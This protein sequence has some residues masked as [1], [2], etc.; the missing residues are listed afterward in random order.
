MELKLDEIEE[1]HLDWI[2]L[3]QDFYGPFHAVVDGALGKIEHAGGAASPYKCLK[4]G[5]PMVYRISKNGF[6]DSSSAAAATPNATALSPSI[7]KANP[8]SAKSANTNAPTAA[9]R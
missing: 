1:Q 5:K 7:A 6:F 3:L 9:A 4:C 8:R 2:K